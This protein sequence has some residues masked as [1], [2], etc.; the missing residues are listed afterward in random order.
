MIKVGEMIQTPQ[1]NDMKKE[2]LLSLSKEKHIQNFFKQNHLDMALMSEYWV[3]LLDFNDDYKLCDNC[4]SLEKCPKDNQGMRKRLACYEGEIVL[5]L[6]SCLYGKQWE[7]KRLLLEKFVITNVNEDML[8]TDLKSLGILKK[9]QLT[10]N[11][12]RALAYIRKYEKDLSDQ[13]LFLHGEIG[14][15][16]TTLLAGL[17]NSL[18]KKGKEIGFIHFPTYLVDLKASFSSGGNE[19]AL[20]KL[21]KVEYLLLDGIGEE[22]I[23]PWSR[24]E[25]LLTILSFRLLNHL[26]TF[27]TS[28]Y[29]YKDLENVYTIKKSDSGDKIRAKTII[30]KMKALSKEIMLDGPKMKI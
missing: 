17:M 8:L 14:S 9:E 2:S 22:N 11:E 12:K 19:Y 28:M 3:E 16:K 4:P 23:T 15:G 7:N 27:F 13:G 1:M 30:Q 25:I 29:G 5:E 21:M 26:P 6:E 24:D 20:E 18:A 10:D